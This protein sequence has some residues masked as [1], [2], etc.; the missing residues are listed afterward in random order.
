MLPVDIQ[1]EA[2][3]TSFIVIHGARALTL[4]STCSHFDI[5]LQALGSV[6]VLLKHYGTYLHYNEFVSIKEVLSRTL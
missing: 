5:E 6:A 2:K 4:G 1:T 3:A